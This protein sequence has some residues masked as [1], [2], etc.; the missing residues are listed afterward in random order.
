MKK[1]EIDMLCFL[2]WL[3]GPSKDDDDDDYEEKC[4]CNRSLIGG[5][6]WCDKCAAEREA[7]E[8]WEYRD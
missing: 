2:G 5:T 8:Q 6:I 7:E 4:T 1:G 3:F